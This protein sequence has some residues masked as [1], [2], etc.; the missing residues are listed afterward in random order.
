MSYAKEFETVD[1]IVNSTAKT[2]GVDAFSLTLIKTERQIRR[3]FTFIV[4]QFPFS[5]SANAVE[6]QNALFENRYVYFEGFVRGIDSIYPR[7]VQNL[8]GQEYL[9]LYNEIQQ[10]IE[11]RNKIFHGQLTDK[12]LSREDLL[13]IVKSNRKWC[14]LLATQSNRE[15]GY[16]GFKR[17]SLRKSE[18]NL[19][20]G[21]KIQISTLAEYRQFIKDVM[22]R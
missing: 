22:Q 19:W 8:I 21:Y 13:D 5:S 18:R 14:A 10:A 3:L 11:Y 4:F 6:F 12:R 17:N 16:D 15:L 2:R 1:L 7:S 9:S 20:E